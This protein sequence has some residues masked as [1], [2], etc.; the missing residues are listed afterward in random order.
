MQWNNKHMI[1]FYVHFTLSSVE[2]IISFRSYNLIFSMS[3]YCILL[4]LY[5]FFSLVNLTVCWLL[6]LFIHHFV[7]SILLCW[8]WTCEGAFLNEVN[9]INKFRMLK[10]VF[11]NSDSQNYLINDFIC[12]NDSFDCIHFWFDC[13]FSSFCWHYQKN[14]PKEEKIRDARNTK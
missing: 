5:L 10:I 1:Y 7:D 2:G 13:F 14:C 6:L 11:E 3:T 9:V 12:I 8:V 4:K